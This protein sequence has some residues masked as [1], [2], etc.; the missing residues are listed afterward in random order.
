MILLSTISLGQDSSWP[1]FR[2]DNKNTGHTPFTGPL[3]PDTVWTFQTNDGLVSSPSIGADGTIYFGSGWYYL[4]G[5]DSC[6]Y[7][8]NPDGSLKWCFNDVKGTFSSATLGSDGTIYFTSLGGIL[9]ALE[10][11]VTYAKEKWQASLEY[12]FSLSSPLLTPDGNIY[13]GSPDFN[14]YSFDTAGNLNWSYKTYWCIIS[15][16]AVTDDGT[17]IVGSKDHNLYAFREELQDTLWAAPLG[18][19]YDGHLVDCSPA[20]GE[21]GTIYVGTD[22]YGAA[23]QIPVIAD[24]NFWAI[25]PDGSLKWA[26][27]TGNGVESSPAIGPDGTVYFGSYD[28]CLYAVADSGTFGFQKWKFKTDGQIDGSPTVDGDGNIYF[29]SRDSVLYCLYPDGSVRWTFDLIDGSECSPTIDDKGYLYVGDFSGKLYCIGT[30]GPDVGVDAILVDDTIYADGT[31]VPAAIAKNYR[32][33]RRSF[34]TYCH[35]EDGSAALVYA[36]TLDLSMVAGGIDININFPTWQSGST[37]GEIY[38]FT[39]GTIDEDDE[40]P[41]NNV[42]TTVTVI[43]ETAFVCGDANGDGT[44]NIADASYILNY[45][46]FGGGR[47]SPLEAADANA[48]GS[49]NIADASYLINGIFFGGDPPCSN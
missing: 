19:F 49:A 22:P 17:I 26:F 38:T 16:A 13:A 46:F 1:K 32:G 27:E 41:E 25:N 20:I 21:D 42:K 4:G 43:S 10:D 5:T 12:F 28:S 35:I 23:Y 40:N 44:V 31:I 29:A 18:T 3:V 47:P 14:F 9:Y 45:I 48:D 2:H 34:K 11:S 33:A 37:P 36:D 8:L 30:G 15:S 24:T 6:F 39:I 7:A